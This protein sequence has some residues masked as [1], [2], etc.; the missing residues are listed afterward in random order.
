MS[1]VK[2]PRGSRR[3]PQGDLF[4]EKVVPLL[5]LGLGLLLLVTLLAALAILLGG[6]S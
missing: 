2:S 5:L 3:M 1:D 6:V 4:Y